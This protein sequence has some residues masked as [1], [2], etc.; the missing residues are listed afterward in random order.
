MTNGGQLF[1]LL[2]MFPINRGQ[3]FRWPNHQIFLLGRS[4]ISQGNFLSN[5]T[6][7]QQQEKMLSQVSLQPQKI[8][9]HLKQS[10]SVSCSVISDPLRPRGLQPTRLLCLWDSPGQ[11]TAVGCHSL[12]QGIFLIQGLNLGL[13]HCRRT[14]FPLSH[15]GSSKAPLGK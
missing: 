14:L 1:S 15:Q 2:A 7:L 3:K 5:N 4:V 10:E 9:H 12:F 13:L 11:N 6:H 8:K